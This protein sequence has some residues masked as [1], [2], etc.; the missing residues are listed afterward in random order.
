VYPRH[1]RGTVLGNY[2]QEY[3]RH[4]DLDSHIHYRTNVTSITHQE[5]ETSAGG[6][7]WTVHYEDVVANDDGEKNKVGRQQIFDKIV[8]AIGSETIAR[9]PV[10]EGL[11]LF[12]GQFLHGQ[13]FK[14]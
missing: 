13:A 1:A 14:R 9:L 4:F 10:I 12:E 7:R 2:Y 5:D 11:D 3:A 6:I 8:Y